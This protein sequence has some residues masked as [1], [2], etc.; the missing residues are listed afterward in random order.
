MK[1]FQKKTKLKI[2]ASGGISE[3]NDLVRLNNLSLYGTI[4]GKALYENRF[5]LKEA[6]TCLQKESSLV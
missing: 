6:L 4:I 1:S 3:L 5:T 2:I